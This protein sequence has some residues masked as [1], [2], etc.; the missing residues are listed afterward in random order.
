MVRS[1]LLQIRCCL[2]NI[3]DLAWGSDLKL[4][5]LSS[6]FEGHCEPR[7]QEVYF[8][9]FINKFLLSTVCHQ[10]LSKTQKKTSRK[11]NGIQCA[12]SVRGASTTHRLYHWHRFST[13]CWYQMINSCLIWTCRMAMVEVERALQALPHGVST[14]E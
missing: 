3:L 4:F 2:H 9:A 5:L 11:A 8:S 6:E 1:P 13:F 7:A 12:P 14:E 10:N